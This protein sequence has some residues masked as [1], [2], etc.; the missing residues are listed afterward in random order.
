MGVVIVDDK[1]SIRMKFKLYPLIISLLA[2]CTSP[3][4]SQ[5]DIEHGYFCELNSTLS[6]E[7]I[8][9]TKALTNESL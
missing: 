4:S 8:L 9:K 2:A 6:V 7:A 5:N 3:N 1:K